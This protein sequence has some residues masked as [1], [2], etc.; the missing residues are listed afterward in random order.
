MPWKGSSHEESG[1]LK[2]G[3]AAHRI[4]Q[5]VRRRIVTWIHSPIGWE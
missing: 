5:Y 4:G 2:H 3:A 1:F